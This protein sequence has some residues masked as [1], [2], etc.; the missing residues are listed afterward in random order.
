MKQN[1]TPGLGARITEK[2]FKEQFRGK[3]APFTMA[4]EGTSEKPGELDAITGATKT[5]QAVLRIVN[6]SAEAVQDLIEATE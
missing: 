3:S 2:W 5:S 4:A 6:R 1:E